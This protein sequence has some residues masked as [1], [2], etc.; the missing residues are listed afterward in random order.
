MSGFAPSDGEHARP[1]LYRCPRCNS[2][3]Y[4]RDMRG[5]RVVREQTVSDAIDWLKADRAQLVVEMA[6]ANAE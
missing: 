5:G 6:D 1:K 2:V 4:A 3:D